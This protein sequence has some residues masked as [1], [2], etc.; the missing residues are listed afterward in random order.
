MKLKDIAELANVSIPTVSRVLNNKEGVSEKNRLAVE[1]ILSKENFSRK[2]I[3]FF[4]NSE[5]TKI[6][7]ILPDLANPFFGKIAKVVSS[8]LRNLNYQTMIFDTDEVYENEASIIDSI[9]TDRDI[10]GVI[11]CI[12]DGKKS[13]SSI[14][15]LKDHHLPV[16]MLDREL[17]FY[18][19][20]IFL[21]D[22]K[23]G[24]LA[25]EALIKAG[26]REIGIITTGPLDLKNIKNRFLGYQH[27]LEK[28]NIIPKK[29]HIFSSS[30]LLN[31]D[32]SSLKKAI[33]SSKSMT[34]IITTNNAM[35]LAVLEYLNEENLFSDL[36]IV[37]IGGF[38]YLSL[39]QSKISYVNWSVTKMGS[40]AVDLLIKK[41]SDK[42]SYTQ[43][44]I[45]EPD[46]ILRGSE[47]II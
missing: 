47:K 14:E 11:I 3:K 41:I 7:L 39:S 6:A 8:D 4:Q 40:A 24:F 38:D 21:D 2:N 23:A 12:A 9:I 27:A 43:K 42:S 31:E 25:T 19:D 34:G 1:K 46:L 22:F 26:H 18:Q 30:L 37:G 5:K 36:S 32:F 15:K 29:E 20:G 17:E 13:L 35:T 16:V 44:I 10:S 45:F 28:Y 33:H